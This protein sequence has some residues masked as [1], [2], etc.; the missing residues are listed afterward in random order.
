MP[1]RMKRL[2]YFEGQGYV[3]D[4]VFEKIMEIMRTRTD[5][6][7]W[8]AEKGPGN[9][10]CED[11]LIKVNIKGFMRMDDYWDLTREKV[12]YGEIPERQRGLRDLIMNTKEMTEEGVEEYYDTLNGFN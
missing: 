12:F 2:I 8:K 9:R 7:E 6:Y 4:R 5:G 11:I 3:N 1:D 10:I